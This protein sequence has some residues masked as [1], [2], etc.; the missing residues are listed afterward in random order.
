MYFSRALGSAFVSQD[1]DRFKQHWVFWV[2]PILGAVTGALSHEFI[3]NPK[4]QHFGLSGFSTKGATVSTAAGGVMGTHGVGGHMGNPG[5]H[6]TT[7]GFMG[8]TMGTTG[9]G[10]M[11]TTTGMGM[12]ATGGMSGGMGMGMG[13]GAMGMGGT[14][15]GGT[16]GPG[17]GMGMGG[18]GGSAG[19]YGTHGGG[20]MG[21]GMGMGRG[22][23]M[24]G[25]PDQMSMRSDE[26]MLDDLERAKQY[27]ANIM[28]VREESWAET[29]FIWCPKLLQG[30]RIRTVAVHYLRGRHIDTD[31]S[32][33]LDIVDPPILFISESGL[34]FRLSGTTG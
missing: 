23:G 1:P 14:H 7:T 6:G 12:G 29:T 33:V 31:G 32:V 17:G 16:Y 27:K 30:S 18:M 22:G 20:G 2:G 4:R 13:G 9:M 28:Q 10:G 26:D 5:H 34:R 24:M 11:S 21:G 15:G 19:P 8:N 25:D 3:F